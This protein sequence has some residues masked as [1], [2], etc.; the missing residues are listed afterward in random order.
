VAADVDGPAATPQK[1]KKE[2]KYSFPS[3]IAGLRLVSKPGENVTLSRR[4]RPSRFVMPKLGFTLTSNELDNAE[5]KK[6]DVAEEITLAAVMALAAVNVLGWLAP[7]R[8]R[9]SHGVWGLMSAWPV[10]AIFLSAL[11]LQASEIRA[12]KRV[13]RFSLALAILVAG[14]FTA[15]FCA[16]MI[17]VW[18]GMDTFLPSTP[19]TSSFWAVNISPQ[20]AGGFALLGLGMIFAGTRGRLAGVAADGLM[21][22]LVLVVLVLVSGH[23]IAVL[24]VFGPTPDVR[25]SSQT[26]LCLL[27][28]TAVVFFRRARHGVF[29][30]FLG[31][32]IGSR[33][34]RALAPVLVALPYLRETLRARILDARQMPPYYMTAILASLAVVVG[35]GLLLFLAWRIHAM[36]SE[37]QALSLR[38]ALTGLYNLRGFRLLAE[39][40][41]HLAKRSGRSFSVLFID[42]DNLKEINDSQGHSA[43]SALLIETGDI[44]RHAFRETDVLGRVGGDEFAVAGQFNRAAISRAAQRLEEFLERHNSETNREAFLSFSAG[45]VTSDAG[46][47]DSLDELLAEADHAMYEEKRRRKVLLS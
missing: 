45:Y 11:S 35:I 40:A 20:S 30:I 46:D 22:C 4:F 33:I 47:G 14:V 3:R 7:A 16:Q 6:L 5:L 19:I 13:R 27:L 38:D 31:R 34:A 26:V 39:Q 37:I 23:F 29:S 44:L 32:G 8:D 17:R 36:E 43:G 18:S 42:L 24:H 25:T 21:A 28:L 10:L 12:R 9:F 2:S 1:L 15:I 41:L